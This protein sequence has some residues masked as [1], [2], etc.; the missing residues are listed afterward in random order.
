MTA[1]D[2]WVRPKALAAELGV[3]ESTLAAWAKNDAGPKRY[4]LGPRVRAYK[5]SEIDAWISSL[6]EPKN[7]AA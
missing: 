6:G 1:P 2:S 5:R 3:A 4:R 7:D